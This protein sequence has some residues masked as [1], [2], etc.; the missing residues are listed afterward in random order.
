MLFFRVDVI[1]MVHNDQCCFLI[2][3]VHVYV[4]VISSRAPCLDLKV[5]HV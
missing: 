5:G 4:L 3:I 1:S 2:M